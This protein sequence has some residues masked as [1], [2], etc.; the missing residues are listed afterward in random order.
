MTA[1]DGVSLSPKKGAGRG[2]ADSA[3]L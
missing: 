3:P 2:R 1:S